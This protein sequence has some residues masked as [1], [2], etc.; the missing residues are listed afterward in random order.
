MAPCGV[1]VD[2]HLIWLVRNRTELRIVVA[3]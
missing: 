3:G 1:A 2:K